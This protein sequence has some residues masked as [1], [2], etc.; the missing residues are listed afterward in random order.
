MRARNAALPQASVDSVLVASHVIT[1][2]QSVVSRTVDPVE[3]AVVSVCALEAGEA[4][5]VLAYLE[6]S[7]QAQI[8][9]LSAQTI[10]VRLLA[11][12]APISG[13]ATLPRYINDWL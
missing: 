4:F 10:D 12:D 1:A 2:L 6:K 7:C 3:S 11:T 9:A 5:N 8:D 13:P